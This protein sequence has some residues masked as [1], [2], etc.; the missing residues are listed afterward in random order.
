MRK[1]GWPMA[2]TIFGA[3]LLTELIAVIG[4]RTGTDNLAFVY[5]TLH[6]GVLPLMCLA[7]VALNAR[8]LWI[9]VRPPAARSVDAASAAIA[10]IYLGL[11]VFRPLPLFGF[12]G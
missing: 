3:T 8:A 6:Y 12:G 5:I 9:D 10:L 1:T 11:L 4:H 7:H 2:I